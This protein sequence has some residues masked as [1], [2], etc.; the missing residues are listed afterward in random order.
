MGYRYEA[1]W[2]HYYDQIWS[3]FDLITNSNQEVSYFRLFEYQWFVVNH[4]LKSIH[5]L[6]P[7]AR[8]LDRFT[9]RIFDWKQEDAAE[10][11]IWIARP[12]QKTREARATAEN[13][14]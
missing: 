5:T 2:I 11:I 13:T 8:N 10:R 1:S 9:V 14:N 12:Q 4:F 6:R 3:Q 7:E